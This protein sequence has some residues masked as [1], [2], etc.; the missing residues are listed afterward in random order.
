M[1][2]NVYLSLER[3]HLNQPHYKSAV[4]GPGLPDGT[5]VVLAGVEVVTVNEFLGHSCMEMTLRDAH[6]SSKNKRRA[7][8]CLDGHYLDTNSKS[9][10]QRDSARLLNLPFMRP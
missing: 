8:Q 5:G 9:T 6:P 2:V 3:G 4:L 7:V 1:H 10:A